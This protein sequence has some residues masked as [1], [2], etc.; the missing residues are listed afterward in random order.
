MSYWLGLVI[1]ELIR[2]QFSEC[3][4]GKIR[5][6]TLKVPLFAERKVCLEKEIHIWNQHFISYKMVPI[7]I[8]F[9]KVVEILYC[10]NLNLGIFTFNLGILV[11]LKKAGCLV[12]FNQFLSYFPMSACSDCLHASTPPQQSFFY[13][14]ISF[15]YSCLLC[16]FFVLLF[17]MYLFCI[18]F[19]VTI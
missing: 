5:G 1:E 3:E 17:I 13:I 15:L 11:T 19:Y 7:L 12:F 6:K 8:T 2:I 16:I 10:V 9:E 18:H 14:F 4:L